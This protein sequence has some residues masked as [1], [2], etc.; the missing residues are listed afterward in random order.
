MTLQS[1]QFLESKGFMPCQKG[2]VSQYFHSAKLC[3]QFGLA[4]AATE[5]L[6]RKNL[7]QFYKLYSYWANN[8]EKG[9]AMVECQTI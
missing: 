1:E 6:E 9:L 8:L 4:C 5:Y 7:Y 3:F 2:K